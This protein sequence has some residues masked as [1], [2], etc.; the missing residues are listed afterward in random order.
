MEKQLQQVNASVENFKARIAHSEEQVRGDFLC[1][2]CN[3]L[4][5]L[6]SVSF[7]NA[8]MFADERLFF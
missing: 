6:S 3:S 2:C 7:T 5:L 1:N 4:K 8:L